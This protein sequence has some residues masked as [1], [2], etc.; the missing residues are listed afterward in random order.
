[1]SDAA[2]SII[3]VPGIRPKP[4]VADHQGQLRRCLHAGVIRAGGTDQEASMIAEMLRVVPW[5]F[6]FYGEYGD[7]Q[8]DLP[9][10]ERLLAGRDLPE[11]AVREATALK[12]QIGGWLYA[13]WDHLPLFAEL[14]AT[15]RMETRLRDVRRY[16]RN[17]DG[18]GL[19]ARREVASELQQAWDK[20]N[21]VILIGHSFGSVIA[22]DTLWELTHE[23]NNPGIVDLYITMG[24]PLTL[25]YMR[26]RLKGARKRGARRYPHGIR[27]W[28]NL[29][30]IGEVTALDRK[31]GKCFRR[32]QK[33]GLTEAISDNLELVNQFHGPAG[34]NVHKCYGYIASRVAGSLLLDWYR[35][36]NPG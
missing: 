34:L 28:A 29:A 33:L 11:D 22:Y 5:S 10:I 3:F 1:M 7:V 27:E 6:G 15:P 12:R 14:F 9:G 21:R 17:R 16:F 19:T 32:M 4:I 35:G 13:L 25:N 31:L 24:S 26:S 2:L 23:Q 36:Q 20:G 30:A 18:A 8:K